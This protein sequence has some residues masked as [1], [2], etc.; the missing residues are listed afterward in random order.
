[1]PSTAQNKARAQ[2]AADREPDPGTEPNPG[3]VEILERHAADAAEPERPV[4]PV[5]Q[6]ASDLARAVTP[7]RAR[8]EAQAARAR[9]SGSDPQQ[10]RLE[11]LF[12]DRL[13]AI[14]DAFESDQRRV[15]EEQRMKSRSTIVGT[16][17]PAG[18]S[19]QPI[20]ENV[21]RGTI[22]LVNQDVR[23]PDTFGLVVRLHPRV[24]V[25]GEARRW[26]ADLVAFPLHGS[27][28]LQEAVPFG[29][30]VGQFREVPDDE[31]DIGVLGV[32]G[33]MRND[34]DRPWESPLK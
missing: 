1:M 20:P 4:D 15:E 14:A 12:A 28:N 33:T 18:A 2:R 13:T 16:G 5:E 9:A 23:V 3:S 11:R 10:A 30:G 32:D 8:E 19:N 27:P 34:Y 29:P 31:D 6:L 26:R 22:V 24:V 17:G 7:G 25:N 21:K